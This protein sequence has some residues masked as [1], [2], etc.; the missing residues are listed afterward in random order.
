MI[1]FFHNFLWTSREQTWSTAELLDERTQHQGL[2][3]FAHQTCP[4]HFGAWKLLYPAQS[5]HT[6]QGVAQ[7][8]RR[9]S[10]L[11]SMRLSK[12]NYFV[13]AHLQAK[14][15]KVLESARTAHRT[16]SQR[17]WVSVCLVQQFSAVIS[18]GRAA[19]SQNNSKEN[20]NEEGGK[21]ERSS[22]GVI[23]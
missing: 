20:K 7:L 10:K 16:S 21:Q 15:F 22:Y 13:W 18:H 17:C 1:F 19:N 11:A 9:H 4:E 3:Y 6:Q 2:W 14:L 12:Y 8:P 23:V 5:G